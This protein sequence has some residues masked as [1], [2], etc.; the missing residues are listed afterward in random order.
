LANFTITTPLLNV[1]NLFYIVGGYAYAPNGFTGVSNVLIEPTYTTSYQYYTSTGYSS[2]EEAFATWANVGVNTTTMGPYTGVFW[3]DF[4]NNYEIVHNYLTPIVN[5]TVTSEG[6]TPTLSIGLSLTVV[7]VT[8]SNYDGAVVIMSNEMGVGLSTPTISYFGVNNYLGGFGFRE[9][10]SAHILQYFV[11]T[12]WNKFMLIAYPWGY[13][14]ASVYNL[15]PNGTYGIVGYKLVPVYAPTR[16]FNETVA[17]YY[18]SNTYVND[19]ILTMN[20]VIQVMVFNGTQ[21]V[22]S[23]VYVTGYLSNMSRAYNVTTSTSGYTYMGYAIPQGVPY[24]F[25]STNQI[26]T[27]I[28]VSRYIPGTLY[29]IPLEDPV[30][31]YTVPSTADDAVLNIYLPTP[32]S[33]SQPPS[34]VVPPNAPPDTPA[35]QMINA[36]SISPYN[37]TTYVNQ[38]FTITVTLSLNSIPQQPI[39][40]YVNVSIINSTTLVSNTTLPIYAWGT[41]TVFSNSTTLTSPPYPGNY[42]IIASICGDNTT[43]PLTVVSNTTTTKGTGT[44]PTS[45]PTNSTSSSGPS[46]S[47]SSSS[48][49]SVSGEGFATILTEVMH[50]EWFWLFVILIIIAVGWWIYKKKTEVVIWI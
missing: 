24:A 19:L 31:N 6:S 2:N 41:E 38:G 42:T 3:T 47:S 34:G 32:S 15:Y 50:S 21:T 12:T 9:Y 25:G 36:L 17:S 5:L 33:T 8:M 35:C 30:Y 49:S 10:T 48:S 40:Y 22:P 37:I 20:Q 13:I 26:Y 45:P 1:T 18:V 28:A 43:D 29:V 16:S 23:I 27:T 46:S 7:N 44:S 14:N 39:D 11:N 4:L